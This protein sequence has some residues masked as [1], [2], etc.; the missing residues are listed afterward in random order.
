MSAECPVRL[1]FI[2]NIRTHGFALE[3]QLEGWC[4]HWIRPTKAA[5]EL[6]TYSELAVFS[7]TAGQ[8]R[9]RLTECPVRLATE[10]RRLEIVSPLEQLVLLIVSTA[11]ASR[12]LAVTD[13]ERSS[14]L[15]KKIVLTCICEI[16]HASNSKQ[17]AGWPLVRGGPHVQRR[18]GPPLPR[19]PPGC[20]IDRLQGTQHR[21]SWWTSQ[22]L[23]LNWIKSRKSP[24]NCVISASTSDSSALLK[25][26]LFGSV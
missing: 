25:W 15:S 1:E 12:S 23:I 3:P 22:R 6:S 7:W 11:L 10:M 19:L 8:Q 4:F 16:S 20:W 17:C 26:V 9:L 18:G 13:V 5:L 14:P 24:R 2:V 21:R